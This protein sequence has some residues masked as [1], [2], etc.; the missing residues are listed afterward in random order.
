MKQ[1][2]KFKPNKIRL[3]GKVAAHFEPAMNAYH[4]LVAP[5]PTRRTAT[6]RRFIVSSYDVLGDQFYYSNP[7][8][9]I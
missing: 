9:H 1:L 2:F 6:G 7:V 5:P 4:R 3:G 8:K